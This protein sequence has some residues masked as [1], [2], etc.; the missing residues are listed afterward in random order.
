MKKRV[1]QAVLV[2]AVLGWVGIGVHG[3]AVYGNNYLNYRG[4][5]PPRTPEGVPKGRLLRVH[6]FSPALGMERSYL[7]YLPPGYE[8]AAAR[9]QRFPVLYFLHGSPSTPDIIFKAGR[10]GVDYDVL[11]H[12]HRIRPFLMVM[13]DGRNGTFMSDT[14]WANTVKDGKYGSF[15]TNVVHAVDRRWAT[16]PN[17]HDRL[18]AGFSEGAYAALNLTLHHL[19]VFGALESWSGYT[20]QS[21]TKGTFAGE[22]LFKVQANEPNMY[23]HKVAR[24][25]RRAGLHAYLYTGQRDPSAPQVINFARE[26]RAAGANVTLSVFPGGHNWRMWRDHAPAMLEWASQ[27]FSAP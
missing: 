17:R 3:A 4:F 16:I 26:L 20:H 24:R 6:F 27:V 23:I 18:I 22:P 14:E 15:V 21:H 7:I 19:P 2:L 9:G 11:L 5:P 10:I 12:E 1:A 13:P 25:V 8:A